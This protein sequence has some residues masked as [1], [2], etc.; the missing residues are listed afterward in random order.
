MAARPYQRIVLKA[1]EVGA[2][3]GRDVMNEHAFETVPRTNV[4]AQQMLRRGHEPLADKLI[5]RI[6]SASRQRSKP[7]CYL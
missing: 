6:V 1:N 2:T 5:V 4:V 7:F 3:V